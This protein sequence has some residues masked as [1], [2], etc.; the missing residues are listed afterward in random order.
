[1]TVV[2]DPTA[3]VEI[4]TL[5]HMPAFSLMEYILLKFSFPILMLVCNLALPDGFFS[6]DRRPHAL[7]WEMIFLDPRNRGG[8]SGILSKAEIN[9][10]RNNVNSHY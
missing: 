1:M 10:S 2:Q 6:H 4:L 8:G 7:L 9:H 5:G 3:Q